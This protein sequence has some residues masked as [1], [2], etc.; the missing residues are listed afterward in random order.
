M[1]VIYIIIG[2]IAYFYIAHVI[3]YYY[4]K[5]KI[6]QSRKKWD[7]NICCG[8]TDDRGVNA[9]IFQHKNVPNFKLVKDIYN[10]PFKNK[11]F[12]NTLCS[13]TIEHVDNPEKFLR[14]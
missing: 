12:K 9:D 8:K 13:Y 2:L 7:L 10:L 4:L 3:S 1:I 11:E 5:N 14:N 6:I